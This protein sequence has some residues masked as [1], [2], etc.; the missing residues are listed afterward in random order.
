MELWNPMVFVVWIF[1]LQVTSFGNNQFNV[2]LQ[3][4][5]T[6]SIINDCEFG[7]RS[8]SI[9]Q[10]LVFSKEKDVQVVSSYKDSEGGVTVIERHNQQLLYKGR[11]NWNK[12]E[13]HIKLFQSHGLSDYIDSYCHFV[14]FEHF[15]DYFPKPCFWLWWSLDGDEAF[16]T[17]CTWALWYSSNFKLRRLY[18]L[19]RTDPI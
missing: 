13:S 17:V 9:S 12:F 10:M 3:R 14:H 15:Q 6:K 2:I 7:I 1:V 11:T 18:A 5:R 19:S 4:E 16:V 8:W